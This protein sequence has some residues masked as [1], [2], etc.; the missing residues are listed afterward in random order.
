MKYIHLSF[1]AILKEVLSLYTV[2]WKCVLLRCPLLDAPGCN[3]FGG[4]N[5]GGAWEVAKEIRMI[6][7]FGGADMDFSE[8]AFSSKKNHIKVI[9]LFGG[10][11]IFAAEGIN[12][13]T[14]AMCIFGGIDNKMPSSF[15]PDSPV[16]II[17]GFVM[18]G[19]VSIKLKK[20]FKERLRNFANNFRSMIG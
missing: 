10:A 12:V 15:S 13:I 14:K 11:N 3:F 20:T 19:G 1:L 17:E 4:T 6:N 8:A 9:C 5:R 7:I 16:I 2:R 18:F